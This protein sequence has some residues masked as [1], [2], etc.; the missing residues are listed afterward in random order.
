MAKIIEHQWKERPKI[1]KVAKF[2]R[3]CRKLTK[4]YIRKFANF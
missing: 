2:E 3:Q 1:S 4:M